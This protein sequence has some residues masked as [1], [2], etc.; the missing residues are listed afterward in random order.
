MERENHSDLLRRTTRAIGPAA[1][2]MFVERG[3]DRH[4][5][6]EL[7]ASAVAVYVLAKFIDKYLDGL[8]DGAE[9]KDLGQAH[10][11]RIKQAVQAA[12]SWLTAV[13]SP[14][15]EDIDRQ[16]AIVADELAFLKRQSANPHALHAGLDELTVLFA[17]SGLPGAEARAVSR[18][19]VDSLW[20]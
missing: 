2:T 16:A 12:G 9:I 5:I 10:G 11:R 3:A 8:T 6:A 18:R 13:T 19:V 4:F 7:T 17:E 1:T 14:S 15:P 20:S